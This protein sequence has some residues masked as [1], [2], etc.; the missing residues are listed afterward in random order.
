C[1]RVRWATAAR[2][3]RAP[4][5]RCT[6][7]NSMPARPAS[8]AR[9]PAT[10]SCSAPAYRSAASLDSRGR[11]GHIAVMQTNAPLPDWNSLATLG[12]DELPLLDTALLIARDEYPDL[13]PAGY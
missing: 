6:C 12:D 7:S 3:T 13:D 1:R 8:S 10:R 11:R 9:G 4:A 5:P 2:P